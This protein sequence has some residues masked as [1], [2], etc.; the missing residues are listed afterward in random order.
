MALPHAC[1]QAVP[2]LHSTTH[3][4]Q[5]FTKTRRLFALF[6]LWDERSV[7]KCVKTRVTVSSRMGEEGSR[8]LLALSL[9]IQLSS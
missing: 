8:H 2:I 6:I 5:Q 3:G 1:K 4:L 7:V 9:S